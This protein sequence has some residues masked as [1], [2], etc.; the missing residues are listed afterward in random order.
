MATTDSVSTDYEVDKGSELFP[1]LRL[2]LPLMGTQLAQMGMGVVDTI[3]AG[4]FG[5]VDLAGVALGGAVMWPC[6]MLMMGILQAVTPT[7]A[8]LKGANREDEFGEVVRQALWMVVVA[9]GLI[10]LVLH[11]AAPFYRLMNVD[12]AAVA[13]ALPYIELTAW[14]VPGML[15]YFVLRFL[16]EGLGFTKPAMFIA[17]TILIIKIPLNYIFINGLFGLPTMGGVGC[18]LATAIVMWLEFIL[19]IFV[20][21]RSRF[22][23]IG[24]HRH[25]ALPSWHII[26]NLLHVGL[27]IG[28]TLFFEIGLFTTVTV[29]LGQIGADAVA[30]HTI[31]MNVGGIT[32]MFPLAL[33]IAASIRIGFNVGA[34]RYDIAR[35]IARV[36]MLS[37]WVVAFISIVVVVSMRFHIASLYTNDTAVYELAAT[38]MLFVAVFQLFDNSQSTAIGA[39]RGYKDTRI[40][41]IITLV[42]YWLFGLPLAASLGFGWFGETYGIFGFWVGL[43]LSLFAVSICA[44]GRLYWISNNDQRIALLSNR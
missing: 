16:A 28:A 3:M 10:I 22:D 34:E 25:F 24:W 23:H 12:E 17:S 26:K 2:A 36:A 32:F 30:S 42:G 14:G 21:T 38:L 7:V 18:G 43:I 15:G 9:G 31:A 4:R 29:L 8:Q 20:V 11:N 39:L 41:M 37:T 5:Y 40:P 27:P 19:I 35:K 1:L 6:T 33:G 13:I 44:M